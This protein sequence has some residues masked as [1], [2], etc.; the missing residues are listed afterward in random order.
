MHTEYK[1]L[2]ELID[3]YNMPV[4]TLHFL[5]IFVIFQGPRTIFHPSDNNRQ[6]RFDA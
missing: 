3:L 1:F 5:V 2:K 4:Y 6:R